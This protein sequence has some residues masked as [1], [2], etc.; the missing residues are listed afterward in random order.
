MNKSN[1]TPMK[2]AVMMFITMHAIKQGKLFFLPAKY[3]KIPE[4][5]MQIPQSSPANNVLMLRTDASI[6]K[7]KGPMTIC[8][9]PNIMC[10][11]LSDCWLVPPSLTSSIIRRDRAKI[12][13]PGAGLTSEGSVG[14]CLYVIWRLFYRLQC[15]QKLKAVHVCC[16]HDDS[17]ASLNYYVRLTI[18]VK[19]AGS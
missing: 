14:G 9:A 8:I 16:F 18:R 12:E 15:S 5:K 13:L 19:N 7:H 2:I 3:P 10:S 17:D 11:L 6:K 1:A 4:T